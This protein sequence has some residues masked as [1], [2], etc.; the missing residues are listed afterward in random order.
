ML[1]PIFAVINVYDGIHYNDSCQP[2]DQCTDKNPFEVWLLRYVDIEQSGKKKCSCQ[3]DIS[4]HSFFHNKMPFPIPCPSGYF[5][6]F[7]I[8][9]INVYC[10]KDAFILR[11]KPFIDN[12]SF[13]A[14][15]FLYKPLDRLIRVCYSIYYLKRGLFFCAHFCA[16]IYPAEMREAVRGHA[17]TC[18]AIRRTPKISEHREVPL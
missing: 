7:F 16:Q 4:D 2:S 17:P 12:N 18:A 5:R 11:L 8:V 9:I 13:H 6:R 3:S 10:D 15:N 1:T 14:C